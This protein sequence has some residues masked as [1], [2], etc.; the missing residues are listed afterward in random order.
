MYI[1]IYTH[2]CTHVLVM[3]HIYPCHGAS[4]ALPQAASTLNIPDPGVRPE[5]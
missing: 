3:I 1:Y 5:Y 2:T 4:L